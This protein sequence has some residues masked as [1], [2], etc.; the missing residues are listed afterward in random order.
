MATYSATDL[1]TKNIFGS[2]EQNG[3]VVSGS[4]TPGAA[5]LNDVYRVCRIPAG[6]IA[7]RLTVKNA[8]LDSNVSPTLTIKAGYLPVDGSAG[9]DNAFIASGSTILQSAAGVAGNAFVVKPV[10]IEKESYLV[11]TVT[12]SAATFA[13]G[14]ITCILEG[15][16]LGSR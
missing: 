10:A 16:G 8:D 15:E 1:L 11:I 9:V 14:E 13:A 7:H 4:I 6:F 2:H 5:T 12:A 3:V